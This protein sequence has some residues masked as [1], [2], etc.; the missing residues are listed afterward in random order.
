MWDDHP[1]RGPNMSPNEMWAL[2]DDDPDDDERQYQAAPEYFGVVHGLLGADRAD[3]AE[4]PLDDGAAGPAQGEP[5]SDVRD[6]LAIDGKPEVSQYLQRA[7]TVLLE[8]AATFPTDSVPHGFGDDESANACELEY[9]FFLHATRELKNL[10]EVTPLGVQ[11]WPQEAW[12]F[13][14]QQSPFCL[15]VN[16]R[17]RIMN[18]LSII[19]GRPPP[20]ML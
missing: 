5:H 1:I 6:L 2:G 10:D 16:M 14:P 12:I 19:S 9:L 7:R 4:A 18:A 20:F 3:R 13:S 17:M 8:A 15:Q 11:V